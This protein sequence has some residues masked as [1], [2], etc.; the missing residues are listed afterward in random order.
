MNMLILTLVSTSQYLNFQNHKVHTLYV[1]NTKF[2]PEMYTV[3]AIEYEY[4]S[5]TVTSL[6]INSSLDLPM[7]SSNEYRTI[8]TWHRNAGY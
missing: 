1:R 7:P 3:S 8:H 4:L 2:N 5:P 6:S